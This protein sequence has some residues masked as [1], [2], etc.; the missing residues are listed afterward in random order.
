MSVL[1][2]APRS[3]VA[4][5]AEHFVDFMSHGDF[6]KAAAYF[7]EK[8]QKA[9]PP[10]ALKQLWNAFAPDCGKFMGRGPSRGQWLR[11]RA[12]VQGTREL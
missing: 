5:T 6:D 7:D 10:A 12:D 8:N 3:P 4:D 11:V 1:P 2:A 9:T